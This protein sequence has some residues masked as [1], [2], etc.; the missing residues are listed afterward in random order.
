M[1]GVFLILLA[2]DE[3]NRL[4]Q[5]LVKDHED[6][7]IWNLS[8]FSDIVTVKTQLQDGMV[9]YSFNLFI[10]NW[11]IIA[12]QCY[13]GFCH[14][15]DNI[16]IFKFRNNCFSPI[17][18]SRNF[19]ITRTTFEHLK[20]RFLEYFSLTSIFLNLLLILISENFVP[21]PFSLSSKIVWL[22]VAPWVYSHGQ[23]NISTCMFL[24]NMTFNTC[25]QPRE[26]P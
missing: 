9:I 5:G 21:S 1:S 15:T 19:F 4:K 6:L 23:Y 20:G 8:A 13:V 26:P 17:L 3:G 25:Y 24:F 14:T 10:F 22:L 2:F 12:L 11:V 16:W 18:I 7:D